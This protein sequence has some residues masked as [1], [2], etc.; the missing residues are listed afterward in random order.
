MGA[1]YLLNMKENPLN[2]TRI[3]QLPGEENTQTGPLSRSLIR[4]ILHDHSHHEALSRPP[5]IPWSRKNSEKEARLPAMGGRGG[6]KKVI[7]AHFE[8]CLLIR[9]GPAISPA[10]SPLPHAKPAW[11]RGLLI[12]AWGLA[13]M[14]SSDTICISMRIL[15]SHLSHKE[16]RNTFTL[17]TSQHP[18]LPPFR[19][20]T[21]GKYTVHFSSNQEC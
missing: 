16:N 14:T 4:A 6:L 7:N 21:P 9:K 13:L 10:M 20:T 18:H 1:I 2:P 19:D 15:G 17:H 12:T 3:M 11:A 8:G 5:F